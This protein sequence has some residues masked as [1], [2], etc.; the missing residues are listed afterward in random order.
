MQ[1]SG[2]PSFS[3]FE[4]KSSH[5]VWIAST[6]DNQAAIMVGRLE[7]DLTGCLLTMEMK[8]PMTSQNSWPVF[9]L[10]Q[11]RFGNGGLWL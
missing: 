9:K 6:G 3:V 11:V 10:I 5:S 7:S 8:K 4:L 2:F 1:T